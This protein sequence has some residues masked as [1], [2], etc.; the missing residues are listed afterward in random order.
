VIKIDLFEVS[1]R[2]AFYSFDG[3]SRWTWRWFGGILFCFAPLIDGASGKTTVAR[4]RGHF[5]GRVFFSFVFRDYR[6]CVFFPR[7]SA[8][9]FPDD[10]FGTILS[11]PRCPLPPPFHVAEITVGY[12]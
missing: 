12:P 8:N 9:F 10:P 2:I 1:F 11:S 4:C 6:F 5:S 7:R 3:F